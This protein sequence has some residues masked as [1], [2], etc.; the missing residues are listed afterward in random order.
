MPSPGQPFPVNDALARQLFSNVFQERVFQASWPI[1][2]KKLERD[3]EDIIEQALQR[4]YEKRDQ[5]RGENETQLLAWVLVILRNLTRDILRSSKGQPLLK[6]LSESFEDKKLRRETPDE[7]LGDAIPLPPLPAIT[8]KLNAQSI[9]TLASEA[10][11][12]VL[13]LRLGH[14]LSVKET[15]EFLST[16]GKTVSEA[17]VKMRLGRAIRRINAIAAR[18]GLNRRRDPDPEDERADAG[19]EE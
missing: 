1:F 9:L 14:G 16:P 6:P 8:W 19:E 2:P 12:D 3:A 5:Y 17:A 10:D 13:L 18:L 4:A 11:R 7:E 15:A